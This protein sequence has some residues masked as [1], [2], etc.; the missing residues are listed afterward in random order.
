LLEEIKRVADNDLALVAE[1]IATREDEGGDGYY[2]AVGL[3]QRAEERLATAKTLEDAR[4][5]ARL[6]GRARQALAGFEHAA[7]CFFDPRHGPSARLTLFAPEGGALRPEPACE[8]CAEE[9]DRG[10]SPPL[11]RV[12]LDGR[13]QPYG[14]SPAHVSYAGR[15][16]RSLDDLIGVSVGEGA[17]GGSP[18][19]SGSDSS[20]S[21]SRPCSTLGY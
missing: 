12:M 18:G 10:R 16:A 4:A 15:G 3:H 9:L 5:A 14:R 6:A 21:C 20:D 1:E 2:E 19:P 8:A 17:E 11:R 13:P 7:P